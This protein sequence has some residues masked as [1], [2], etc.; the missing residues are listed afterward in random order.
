VSK[1]GRESRTTIDTGGGDYVAGDKVQGDKVA[2]DKIVL[3]GDLRGANVNVKSR[4]E[5]VTQAIGQIPSADP[6]AKDELQTLIAQLQ[7]ALQQAP[8][9]K[10]E[11]AEAVAEYAQELVDAA[12]AD[13]PNKTK[14]KITGEGLKMAAQ[15]LATV[16]P[17][18]LGIA[19]QI[20]GVVLK[21]TGQGG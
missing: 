1:K 17:S 16:M 13:K 4:L 3:S 2:G 6:S 18:V 8:E 11:E 5:N 21:L 19:T 14:V 20:V 12:A 10:E 9:G 15:N 7:E